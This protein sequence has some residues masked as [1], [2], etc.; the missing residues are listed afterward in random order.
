MIY[1]TK[2]GVIANM[3]N[4]V[5]L[6]IAAGADQPYRMI[7][8]EPF[9]M[10]RFADTAMGTLYLTFDAKGNMFSQCIKRDT[11]EPVDKVKFAISKPIV[12][13]EIHVLYS[14][15]EDLE[16]YTAGLFKKAIAK[17]RLTTLEEIYALISNADSGMTFCMTY[18]EINKELKETM[19]VINK[20][21]NK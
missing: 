4:L 1:I 3:H 5:D 7:D 6:P 14:T 21:N 17:H 19:A 13:W 11:G 18:E 15:A 10:M 16:G 8:G 9:K 20:Y 2:D 12:P